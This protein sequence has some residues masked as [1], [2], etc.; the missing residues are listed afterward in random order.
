MRTILT[1][2]QVVLDKKNSH[3][4]FI[5]KTLLFEFYNKIIKNFFC[6]IKSLIQKQE[7]N[8]NTVV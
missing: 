6:F 4:K 1:D 2:I 3:I 7:S 8:N 5:N